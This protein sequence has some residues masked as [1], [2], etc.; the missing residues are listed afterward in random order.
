[1]EEGISP[2]VDLHTVMA[3]ARRES[4]SALVQLEEVTELLGKQE[5]T[6]ALGAFEGLDDRVHYV[7]VVLHRFS[8]HVGLSR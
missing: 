8:R 4:A 2:G 5:Y 6:R 3:D 7:A 1:M